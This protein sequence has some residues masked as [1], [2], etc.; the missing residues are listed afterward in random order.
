M[1]FTDAQGNSCRLVGDF[2]HDVG[3]ITF[4][5]KENRAHFLVPAS[6]ARLANSLTPLQQEAG[7][8]FNVE[9][10]VDRDEN[11]GI[12]LLVIIEDIPPGDEVLVEYLIGGG[13]I[14]DS[15][16]PKKK[17]KGPSSEAPPAHRQ[18]HNENLDKP[19]STRQLS[20]RL[21]GS[22]V[23]GTADFSGSSVTLSK[24]SQNDEPV[25]LFRCL[26]L[27]EAD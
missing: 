15:S 8:K 3:N 1:V 12:V 19:L 9:F 2:E 26:Q 23:M 16:R 18:K 5:F 27:M 21:Q 7:K 20:N 14:T 17:R 25:S 11:T 4:L 13:S 22:T 24:N 6:L 10:R